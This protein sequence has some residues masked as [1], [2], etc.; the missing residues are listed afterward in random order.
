[1]NRVVIR[2][3]TADR[4][5]QSHC[6]STLLAVAIAILLG[7]SSSN[8]DDVLRSLALLSPP[9]LPPLVF[10]FRQPL[11][12]H[13]II[14]PIISLCVILVSWKKIYH[15]CRRLFSSRRFVEA[16]VEIT[17]LGVQLV[18]IYGTCDNNTDK[19][20][21]KRR[22][23]KNNDNIQY[24]VRAF[25]PRPKIVDVIVMEVVWPHC[26]WSQVVFRVLDEF[27]DDP[28][29]ES[30]SKDCTSKVHS[31][32]KLLEKNKVSIIPAYPEECRGML[33]YE[34]CLRVQSEI[35]ELLGLQISNKSD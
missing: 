9:W 19:A 30:H 11:K 6:R 13:I 22:G 32:H 4:S 33:S 16:A 35:E 20:L 24:K 7:V 29:G 14:A 23:Y 1:M 2:A 25:L 10:Q 15:T 21:S 5:I 18:S 3:P 34:Q 8:I 17:P 31:I 12:T 28:S 26:V 27:D